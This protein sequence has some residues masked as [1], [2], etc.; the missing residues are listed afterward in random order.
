M[1]IYIFVVALS[2]F[3]TA[4]ISIKLALF[5]SWLKSL[6]VFP[7]CIG[8]YLALVALYFLIIF[9]ISLTV[10]KRNPRSKPTIFSAGF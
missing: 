4:G 7:I 1:I 2:I 5:D 10:N 6:L 3:F 9:L 8:S